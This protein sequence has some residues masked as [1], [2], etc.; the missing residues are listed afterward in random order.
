VLRLDRLLLLAGFVILL[1]LST[2]YGT[3]GCAIGL[4]IV[5]V[6]GVIIGLLGMRY[7]RLVHGRSLRTPRRN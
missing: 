1:T 7:P 3:T 2:R 4:G 5:A 6:L